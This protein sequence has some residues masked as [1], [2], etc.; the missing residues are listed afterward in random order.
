MLSLLVLLPLPWLRL[1]LLS[2]RQLPFI[3]APLLENIMT[4]CDLWCLRGLRGL[5]CG[6][7]NPSWVSHWHRIYGW[8]CR[9]SRK[10]TTCPRVAAH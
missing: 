1:G 6:W 5:L 4:C 7:P 10:H 2:R 3:L 8:P 9:K